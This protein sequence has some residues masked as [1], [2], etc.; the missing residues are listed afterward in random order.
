MFFKNIC[1]LD[2]YL[3]KQNIVYIKQ[4]IYI[5]LPIKIIKL[6]IKLYVFLYSVSKKGGGEGGF[7]TAEETLPFVNNVNSE[8]VNINTIEHGY[9]PLISTVER[10][11]FQ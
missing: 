10:K 11:T 5:R 1:I 2:K 9:I 4:N 8:Y 3:S 7:R 6:I